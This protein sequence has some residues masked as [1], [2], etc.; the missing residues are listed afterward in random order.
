M[1]DHFG[2]DGFERSF[3]RPIEVLFGFGGVATGS[4]DVAGAIEALVDADEGLLA[5]SVTG[6]FVKTFAR[7]FEIDVYLVK[8]DVHEVF[9]GVELA[10]GEDIVLWFR[11]VHHKAEA[12]HVV[13]GVSP[14]ALRLDVAKRKRLTGSSSDA[15]NGLYNL[16]GD[17]LVA[18][19][20]AFVVEENSCGGPEFVVLAVGFDEL[21]AELFGESVRTLGI[22][23]G[24]FALFAVY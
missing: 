9:D 14:V 2:D 19:E 5:V 21:E 13:F 12:L 24:G 6:G 4:C 7:P 16:F 22:G 1:A 20:L 10:G 15:D 3:W 11:L 8:S 18:T 23:S 17:E